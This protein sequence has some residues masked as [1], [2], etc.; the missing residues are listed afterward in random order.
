MNSELKILLIEDNNIDARNF[1]R[2]LSKTS[3]KHRFTHCSSSDAG[4]NELKN[5][6]FDLV[7]LDYHLP[8]ISGLN[9]LKLFKQND[10]EVPVIII[11]SYADP[12]T[13]VELIKAGASDYIPKSLLNIEGLTH[14]VRTCVRVNELEKRKKETEIRLKK[15][16][17]RLG[18]IISNT[19]IILFVLDETGCFSLGIGKDWE[20]FNPTSNSVIGL[21]F[22]DL[23]KE[24]DGLVEC[25]ENAFLG[26]ISKSSV[27]INNIS[28]EVTFTPSLQENGEL[29]EIQG[30][31]LDVTGHVKGRES[32][33]EAKKIAENASK[34]K[35]GFVANMSHEIRTPMNAII[36]FTNLLNETSLTQ[37][38]KEFVKAI[39]VSGENL[40]NLVNNILDFSKIEAD[41]IQIDRKDFILEDIL[42]NVS[43]V[44]EGK[45]NDKNLK[46]G[47]SIDKNIPK[48]VKGDQTRLY[49]ILINLV[50]NAIKFTKVG[51]VF[52]EVRIKSKNKESINLEF[53]VVDSGV[54]I[55]INKQELIFENFMQTEE[56]G[57]AHYGGTGLGLTIV[58]DLLKLMDGTISVKSEERKGSSFTFNLSLEYAESSFLSNEKPVESLVDYSKLKGK[59]I[60]LAEDNNM[61]QKLVIMYLTK[62]EVLIDLAETGLQAVKALKSNDYDLILM[63][64][65]MPDM[66]GIEA[67]NEIRNFNNEHKRSTPILAMTA[68]AFTKEIEKCLD[69]GMNDHVSK[70]IN[71]EKFLNLI[72]KLIFSEKAIDVV[73]NKPE[74]FQREKP[75]VDLSYLRDMSEGNEGFVQTMIDIFKTDAPIL[76]SDMKT[77]FNDKKWV[78]LSK[79]A[80]K[81][82]S[83]TV[84][85]GMKSVSLLAEQVEYNDFSKGNEVEIE[86][87]LVE[88][89]KQSSEAINYIQTHF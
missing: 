67:T 17:D 27:E 69:A 62:Y 4:F 36:G 40:H 2:V 81:Y 1:E 53:E 15:V 68:Y 35:Q 87:L 51:G 56:G 38:Q 63:D 34:M 75:L 70:P 20:S 76:I 14:C 45:I 28:F 89:E 43:K 26:R 82:R 31:A 41:K 29:N 24:Y 6:E 50:G 49:Q 78:K 54:G 72:Y 84:I 3:I 64:I 11:T 66:D 48:A 74:V 73:V 83:P 13:A 57:E 19:P 32:L 33:N 47:F 12:N 65:Q 44:L 58:R 80:H 77:A 55:P 8:S 46:L 79:L 9:L 86:S 60:L 18:S 85:M 21:S 52:I 10:I 59:R 5:N 37:A 22:R 25:F 30:L 16:E 71:K 39:N 23:Y 42:E 7:F 88:I 61:N